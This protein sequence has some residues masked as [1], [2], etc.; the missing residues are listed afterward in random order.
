MKKWILYLV[1][2][3]ILLGCSTGHH[4]DHGTSDHD[5]DHETHDTVKNRENHEGHDH[6]TEESRHQ[7]TSEISEV[8][9]EHGEHITMNPD[10]MKQCGI[11]LSDIR[12]RTF[13]EQ[14]RAPGIVGAN[15]D[16]TYKINAL[17]EGNVSAIKRDLG[18]SVRIGD[19]LCTL[20]SPEY[21]SLKNSYLQAYQKHH[22][23]MEKFNRAR[24]LYKVK[25]IDLKTFQERETGYKQNLADYYSLES[26]LRST[27]MTESEIKGIKKAWDNNDQDKIRGFLNPM[28]PIR[29]PISGTV[30]HR[31]LKPGQW[32]EKNQEI[33][34]VSDTRHVWVY[35]NVFEKD[36]PLVSLGGNV[37]IES[38]HYPLE[39]FEGKIINI[40]Q[41]LDPS[42]RT[43]KVRV[44]VNNNRN[45]LKP[46]MYVTGFVKTKSR[47]DFL[48]VPRQ[49]IVRISSIDGVF[50]QCHEGFEFVPVKILGRDFYNNIFIEGLK[51]TEK[52]VSRGA[53]YLKAQ[54]ELKKQGDT[55]GH[56]HQH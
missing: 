26:E 35:L 11:Q 21:L 1:L 15:L 41:R 20:N 56:G 32:I 51:G 46:D 23:L 7:E 18:D 14:F 45:L 39:H 4:Q 49:A 54:M 16:T 55:G 37:R 27:G 13:T 40:A 10:M 24:E 38:D 12:N 25:G 2:F 53:Y 17:A 50:I 3:Y 22:L 30:I 28:Y 34:E 42:V 5:H 29:T 44:A 19:I 47:G 48:S 6:G 52:I 43:M 31:A 36:I 9:G 8:A 33:F